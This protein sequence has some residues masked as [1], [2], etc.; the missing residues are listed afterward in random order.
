MTHRNL[1]QAF[2]ETAAA[3]PDQEAFAGPDGAVDYRRTA[4]AAAAL[5]DRLAAR[6]VG[7]GDLVAVEMPVGPLFVVGVL[8][9]T[10][11][12][13]AYIPL[14]VTGPAKRREQILTDARPTVVLRAG[15]DDVRAVAPLLTAPPP[16]GSPGPERHAP[17][18]D[19]DDPAYVIYTSGSTGRPKGVVVPARGVHT[20]LAAFQRRAPLGPGARHSWWTSPG[21]DVSVYEMWSALTSGGT[22]V[23]VPDAYRRDIDATLDH[24][25]DQ[26]VDSAYLP[27]QFLT[28]L[29]D[30]TAGDRT[31][32]ARPVPRLRRLL[33]GV[34]PIPLG[35]LVEL[36]EHTPGLVVIN[37][38]GPTETTVCA[39]LYTVPDHCAE[40][41]QRTPIGAVVEGNR[42]FVLDDRLAP[43]EQGRPGELCVAGPGVALGYLHD[44]DRTAER[45]VPAADGDGLMYRTGDIVVADAT[46]ELTFLGRIDDQLKI[47][48]VR[49]EPAETEAALRRCAE[50]ADVAVLARP[51][52]PGGPS[53]LTA[54]VVLADTDA[55]A[56]AGADLWTGLKARLAD[57]LPSQAVPRRFFALERIPM[58][59]DGKLDR[60]ALPTSDEPQAR[61]ALNGYERAVEDACRTVLTHAPASALDLGFAEA[62]GDSLQATRLSAL[63]RD[64]TGRAVTAGDVLA[65]PTLAA[66]AARLPALPA[67]DTSGDE[68]AAGKASPLTPGQAGIWA[69]ELTGAAPP[70][71]FHESVA[72]EFTGPLCPERT[73]KELAAVLDR[74]VVFRGR[75]DEDDARFVTDGAPVSVTVRSVASGEDVDDAWERLLAEFQRP[76]FDLGRGPL[77]RAAVLSAADTVRVLLVWHHLVVDAWS[78]RVV[79]EE[80]A[81]ALSGDAPALPEDHGH[82]GYARRQRRHLDSPE[83]RDAVRAAADRARAWLPERAEPGPVQDSCRVD[84]FTVGARAWSRVRDRARRDGTT[85]FA[86]VLAATLDPLCELAG[87]DGRFAL[88]VADRDGVDAV[89]T[90][91]YLLTT[92]PFGPPPGDAREAGP[93]LALRRARDAVAEARTWSRV[94]FPTLMAALGV[95]EAGS[96]A[97]LVIAWDRDPAPA[98]S[99]P[100]CTARSLP[101]TPL[102]V[103]WPWTVLLTDH[104]ESGLTGRIE[105]PP[106]VSRDRVLA[107]CARWESLLDAFTEN[108]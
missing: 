92:V 53:V 40:P 54:F 52:S 88:A 24:L 59:S 9:A 10:A 35:L 6:N 81:A 3:H 12:G 61:T 30:R 57:E 33:T 72:V 19:G 99:V 46:G 70:G 48:G 21:F 85:A 106:W 82:A 56:P 34:E 62:G 23:P 50:I 93:A 60:P 38:Y 65:A 71:T 2:V 47:D 7:A 20:L 102:G 55:D 84:G 13:A 95:R 8:A 42:G 4:A 87:T 22:V 11:V 101:V 26:R 18:T 51:A 75:V 96:L 91:G 58:T 45:F 98:L 76:P 68:G 14:D 41:Q 64:A 89:D 104:G 31:D 5:A 94:P 29:R 86:V 77:V 97:P 16:A 100:G 27:P 37:G 32:A 107:L 63:L 36:R 67:A 17:A 39:T 44:P 78:A 105:Y 49:I 28:A 73:A 80:L 15:D 108:A 83:G 90:A 43:V 74:H 25:A 1:W 103:R 79:L 66:L 69:A